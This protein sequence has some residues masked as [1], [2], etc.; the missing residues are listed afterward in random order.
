MDFIA[1]Q[2]RFRIT[3]S[4]TILTAITPEASFNTALNRNY[5]KA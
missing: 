4:F 5:A 2:D 3:H 1:T